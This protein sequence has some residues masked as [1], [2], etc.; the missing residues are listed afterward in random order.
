[1][2]RSASASSL[3]AWSR[4]AWRKTATRARPRRQPS[5]IDAW[6]SSS[7]TT[8]TPGVA[9]VAS[10]PRLAAKPD[11]KTTARSVRFQSARAASS[12]WC[13]GREPTMRRAAPEP[14]PHGDRAHPPAGTQARGGWLQLD[15]AH[16]TPQPDL[17]DR[18]Q[19]VHPLVE[20]GLQLAR[21][22]PHVREQVPLVE[23]LEVAQRHRSRER[24]PA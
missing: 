24:V 6:L 16:E 11:G 13:T 3:A 5:M 12:S 15:P 10:T 23:Q 14:A 22:R 8:V 20:Q 4:S 19:L 21:A 9:K 1:M 2:A 18:V 17:L 7:L